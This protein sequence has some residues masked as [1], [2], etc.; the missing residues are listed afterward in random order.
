MSAMTP[1]RFELPESA[2]L[3]LAY[4]RISGDPFDQRRGVKR[5]QGDLRAHCDAQDW[6]LYGEYSDNDLSALSDERPDYD[7]LM[8]AAIELGPRA[9]AAGKRVVVFRSRARVGRRCWRRRP[10]SPGR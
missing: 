1:T 9:A 10:G 8:A 4:S 7:R 5:Q 3:A 2:F 6:H